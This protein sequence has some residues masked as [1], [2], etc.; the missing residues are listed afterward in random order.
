MGGLAMVLWAYCGLSK[1]ESLCNYQAGFLQRVNRFPDVATQVAPL[2]S[3]V[4][5]KATEQVFRISAG[6]LI[7]AGTHAKLTHGSAEPLPKFGNS[8]IERRFSRKLIAE[9]SLF[10]LV[11]WLILPVISTSYRGARCLICITVRDGAQLM[12]ANLTRGHRD[13]DTDPTVRSCLK[14]ACPCLP[15][16]PSDCR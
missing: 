11:K 9:Y 13:R 4:S 5:K 7:G 15:D 12:H 6:M 2:S 3:G 10:R 16:N 1:F 14:P 8:L